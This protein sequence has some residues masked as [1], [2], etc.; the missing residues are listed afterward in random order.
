ETLDENDSWPAIVETPGIAPAQIGALYA[1]SAEYYRAA[2]WRRAGVEAMLRIEC[3]PQPGAGRRSWTVIFAGQTSDFLG[4][5]LYEDHDEECGGAN[6]CC[7]DEDE[8]IPGALSLLF[9]EEFEIP[10][11][12]FLAREAHDWPIAGPEAYPL[13]ICADDGIVHRP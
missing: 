11:P 8:A 4:L 2:P 12:D 1:A 6:S 3:A 5:A 13:V 9:A 7:A 10:I